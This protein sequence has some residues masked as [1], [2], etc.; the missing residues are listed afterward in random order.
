MIVTLLNLGADVVSRTSLAFGSDGSIIIEVR[1][2]GGIHMGVAW[3]GYPAHTLIE[4]C[5]CCMLMM[6][7]LIFFKCSC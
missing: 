3:G 2:R 5:Q 1:G 7:A 4:E 6:F